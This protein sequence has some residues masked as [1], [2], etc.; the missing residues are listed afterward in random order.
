MPSDAPLDC[1]HRPPCGGCALLGLPYEE[2]LE[3]KRDR[4]RAALAR[5]PSQRDLPV[6]GCLPAPSPA[7]YRTRAKLA[8]AVARGASGAA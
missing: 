4:V 5:F 6:A 2:Q 8:V 7:G 3:R 1:P